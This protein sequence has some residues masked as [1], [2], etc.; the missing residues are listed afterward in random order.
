MEARKEEL[1]QGCSWRGMDAHPTGWAVRYQ[2]NWRVPDGQTQAHSGATL[3]G[4]QGDRIAQI[5]AWASNPDP[6]AALKN[7]ERSSMGIFCA[8]AGC[9]RHSALE[10]P[11]PS[12]SRS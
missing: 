3:F 9:F 8:C 1:E 4:F 12:R 7:A 5:A 2:E 6:A 10:Q 11:D